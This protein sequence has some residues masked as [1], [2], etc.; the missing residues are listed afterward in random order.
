VPAM[1]SY[2]DEYGVSNDKI[3]VLPIAAYVLGLGSVLGMCCIPNLELT[4]HS[5]GPFISAPLS[6]LYG[7]QPAYLGS[8]LPFVF[9]CVAA[10]LSEKYVPRSLLRSR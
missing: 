1:Q 3:G 9:F 2:M 10:G 4:H 8:L 5:C 6:E 7:R